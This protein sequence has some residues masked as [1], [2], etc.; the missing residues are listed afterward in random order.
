MV[1]S[2]FEGCLRVSRVSLFAPAARIPAMWHGGDDGNALEWGELTAGSFAGLLVCFPFYHPVRGVL[3]CVRR[4][5]V[6]SARLSSLFARF[7]HGRLTVG[8]A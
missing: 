5:S 3:E 1:E 6:K 8:G 2:R 4:V 7:G